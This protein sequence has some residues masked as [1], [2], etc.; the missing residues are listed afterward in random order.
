MC[1]EKAPREL[2]HAQLG[3]R[4][5]VFDILV[6]VEPVCVRARA[7]TRARARVCTYVCT[8]IHTYT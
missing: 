2:A 5:V 3:Q 1:L 4:V 6:N 7:R 8:Y